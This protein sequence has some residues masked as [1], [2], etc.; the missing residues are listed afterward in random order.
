MRMQTRWTT[1]TVAALVY[2]LMT[3]WSALAADELK[4]ELEYQLSEIGPPTPASGDPGTPDRQPPPDPDVLAAKARAAVKAME[5]EQALKH[6]NQTLKAAPDHISATYYRAVAYDR[7][8]RYEQA[9]A[10]Y[11][12]LIELDPKLA[13]SDTIRA[14]DCRGDCRLKAGQMT[15]A[16]A[17]F[18]NSLRR[19]PEVEPHHW[20]RGIAF[21]YAREYQ[22]GV[23]QFEV[24]KTVNADDVENSVWHFLCH[25]RI[26]GIEKARRA[27]IPLEGKDTR[28]PLMTVYEMFAGRAAP[29][30]VM[31]EARK[32]AAGRHTAVARMA[33]PSCGRVSGNSWHRSTCT[34]SECQRHGL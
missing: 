8:K 6:A 26:A 29:R 3:G 5:F 30:D 32:A 16:I 28:V 15:E 18:D 10:D 23:K 19:R 14:D 17:D 1:R 22:R 20:R 9:I 4:A 27:L 2:V 33:A 34:R 7:L 11:T 31:E 25:A 12:R 21:Y 13:L 24:H